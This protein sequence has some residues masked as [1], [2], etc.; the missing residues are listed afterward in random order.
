MALVKINNVFTWF[1][2][3]LN[4]PSL[5]ILNDW[6]IERFPFAVHE[7]A[8]TYVPQ[9]LGKRYCGRGRARLWAGAD[10]RPSAPDLAA[11]RWVREFAGGAPPDGPPAPGFQFERA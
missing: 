2:A 9:A 8:D 6:E 1:I 7:R 5:C 4:V 10:D 11:A 3:F